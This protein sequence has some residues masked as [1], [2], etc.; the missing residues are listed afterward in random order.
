MNMNDES[1]KEEQKGCDDNQSNDFIS[2]SCWV[3]KMTPRMILLSPNAIYLLFYDVDVTLDFSWEG[4][5]LYMDSEE[6]LQTVSQLSV[7]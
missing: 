7:A 2:L 5:L 6:K 4:E 1:I 3:T